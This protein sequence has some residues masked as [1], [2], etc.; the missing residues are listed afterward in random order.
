[1]VSRL[2]LRFDKSL[3]C[4]RFDF[5]VALLDSELDPFPRIVP[6]LFRRFE[7]SPVPKSSEP[8]S[9]DILLVL[10]DSARGPWRASVLFLRFE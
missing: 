8:W 10:P 9:F 6:V 7:E 3:V 4:C 1:M 5:V 2:F